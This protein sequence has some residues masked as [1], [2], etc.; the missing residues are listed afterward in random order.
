MEK[1]SSEFNS[2]T[3][4]F[5]ILEDFDSFY[6]ENSTFLTTDKKGQA[7]DPFLF[8]IYQVVL[9]KIEAVSYSLDTERMLN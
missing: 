8:K 6:I 2:F 7:S 9:D 4:L 5:K 1:L 3:K